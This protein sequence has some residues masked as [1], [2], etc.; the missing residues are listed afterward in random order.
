MRSLEQ[1][2]LTCYRE[3]QSSIWWGVF[4]TEKFL[5]YSQLCLSR[6]C[7]D[8]RNSFDF[9]KKSTYEGLKTIENK[10]KTWTDLR[11]MQ[12]WLRQSWLY[13]YQ[14]FCLYCISS[15]K[16]IQNKTKFHWDGTDFVKS[17]PRALYR[18]STVYQPQVSYTVEPRYKEVGY[19]KT[20]L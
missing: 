6:I 13:M 18:G 2:Q 19:N 11:L 14:V 3:T 17:D 16:M 7:W 10:E 1:W 5:L 4:G 8:W 15:P 12:I 20:L 9:E